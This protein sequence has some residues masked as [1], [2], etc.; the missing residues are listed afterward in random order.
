[1][2]GEQQSVKHIETIEDLEQWFEEM[3]RTV[4]ITYR[5]QRKPTWVVRVFRADRDMQGDPYVEA[6]HDDFRMAASMAIE[7]W[8]RIPGA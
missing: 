3:G 4:Q 5:I 8:S 6:A 7:G 1:M 2:A